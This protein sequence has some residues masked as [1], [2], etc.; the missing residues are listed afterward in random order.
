LILNNIKL[1][2]GSPDLRPA[3]II[4]DGKNA[5]IRKSVFPVFESAGS[6]IRLEEVSGAVISRNTARGKA[7]AFVLVEGLPGDRVK[8]SGNRING[9][10]QAILKK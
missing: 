10:G 8:L 6:V 4:Q 5:E 2:L 9:I 3:V 7:E 1:T